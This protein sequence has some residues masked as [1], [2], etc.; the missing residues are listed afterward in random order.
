MSVETPR[1]ANDRARPTPVA[2]ALLSVFCITASGCRSVNNS[3]PEV[4]IQDRVISS[5]AATADASTLHVRWFAAPC[6]T[7]EE[8]QHNLDDRYV[9]LRVVVSVDVSDCP[10][11]SPGQTIVDL[12][13]PVGSRKVWDLAFNDTVVI[14]K[15]P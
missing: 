11:S 3:V 13:E 1:V 10:A 15:M 14:D 5:V 9:N 6:E 7:F 2:L 4:E 8:V 12:G